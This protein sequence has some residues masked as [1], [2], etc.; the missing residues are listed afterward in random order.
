MNVF[1]RVFNALIGGCR[2]RHTYRERRPLHGTEIMHLVC[3]DCGYAVPAVQ[4]TA[5]EH[6]HVVEE[7]AIKP[8]TV[9]RHSADVL[10][11]DERSRVR[12]EERRRE[13][14]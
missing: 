12:T 10:V 14:S 13:A 3:E 7:G 1:L 11:M 2:H 4:R 5:E 9:R 6:R 8:A